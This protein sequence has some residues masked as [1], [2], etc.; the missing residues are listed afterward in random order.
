MVARLIKAGKVIKIITA[1]QITI[2]YT[3]LKANV[4][5]KRQN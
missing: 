3:H 2:Y 4:N 5:K 1:P